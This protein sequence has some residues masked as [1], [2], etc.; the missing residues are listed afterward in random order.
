MP[1]YSYNCRQCG[2]KFELLRGINEKDGELACPECGTM[3][4]EKIFLPLNRNVKWPGGV[5]RFG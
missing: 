2:H 5:F 3:E 4:P 1:M